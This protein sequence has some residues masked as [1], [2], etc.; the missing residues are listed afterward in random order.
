MLSVPSRE[1]LKQGS[2]QVRRLYTVIIDDPARQFHEVR[3]DLWGY[4]AEANRVQHIYELWQE[5]LRS[6]RSKPNIGLTL[7]TLPEHLPEDNELLDTALP[8]LRL[9]C[10]CCGNGDPLF[11]PVGHWW[12][13]TEV[14]GEY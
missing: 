8:R 9:K 14:S 11:V 10:E 6:R 5:V 13:L 4:S 3:R 2:L 12:Q 1:L 7:I